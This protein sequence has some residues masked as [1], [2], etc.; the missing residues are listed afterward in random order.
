M[1]NKQKAYHFD[2]TLGKILTV[3]LKIGKQTPM[4]LGEPGIGKSSFIE[5]LG[6]K[7]HTQVFTVTCNQLADRG[8]LIAPKTLKVEGT[9]DRY[10]QVFFPHATIRACIDYA[11]DHPTENPILFLDEIN[12]ASSDITSA[13]LSFTTSRIIG[14]DRL[15]DNV[16]FVVAGNDK[17]N[18][19]SFDDASISRFS[20]Y[21]IEP[22]SSTFLSL[23]DDINPFVVK[24]L[25]Q[26]PNSIFGKFE[27]TMVEDDNDDDDDDGRLDAFLWDESAFEQIATPRTIMG[28][29]DFL[30]EMSKDD[31]LL[32]IQE[33]LLETTIIGKVGDTEFGNALIQVIENDITTIASTSTK[34]V[35]A[36]PTVYDTLKSQP[37]RTQMNAFVTS[38]TDNDKSGCLVYALQENADNTA[39]IQALSTNMTELTKDDNAVI[40]Q[41]AVKH[42]LDRQN[43]DTLVATNSAVANN[44][45]FILDLN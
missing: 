43:T 45:S 36:K 39:I 3:D 6:R 32:L 23:S 25:Q 34:I 38:M 30:N 28:I 1:S 31:L 24:T 29:S 12:R 22:D 7:F 13:V 8:D 41:I 20:L 37:D 33:D 15:P 16:R 2:E 5:S 17:G 18:V 40:A 27:G 11:K 42:Q 21:R 35:V 19:T 44:L 9:T 14:T 10:E 4:L 26:Y